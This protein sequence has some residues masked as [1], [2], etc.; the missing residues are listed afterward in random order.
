M[1]ISDYRLASSTKQGFG[2]FSVDECKGTSR[3]S[4]V[5]APLPHNVRSCTISNIVDD[6]SISDQNEDS[7]RPIY[8][9]LSMSDSITRTKQNWIINVLCDTIY[10]W[11]IKD[12]QLWAILTEAMMMQEAAPGNSFKKDKLHMSAGDSWRCPMILGAN[13]RLRPSRAVHNKEFGRYQNYLSSRT[14]NGIDS[15]S[16]SCII[17]QLSSFAYC[18]PL[19]RYCL[20]LLRL[21]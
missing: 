15:V 4:Q 10:L 21:G 13:F 8:G 3:S 12:W 17:V 18:G 7:E 6:S 11:F 19:L 1:R 2:E 16:H 14:G 9:R 20:P 5:H